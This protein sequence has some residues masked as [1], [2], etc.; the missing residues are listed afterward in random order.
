MSF[1]YHVLGYYYYYYVSLQGYKLQAWRHNPSSSS[2]QSDSA[3]PPRPAATVTVAPDLLNPLSEQT[4]VIDGL[5]PWT[6][7]NITVLCFTSPGD[8]VS[9][10]P[11]LVRT[12]Q[13]REQIV[14][15]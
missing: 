11:E 7:Y 2:S 6:A 1:T 13:V 4:S 15:L 8:G 9:S 14:Q 3:L 5:R 12:H 10:P